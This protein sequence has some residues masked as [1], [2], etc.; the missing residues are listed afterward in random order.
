MPEKFR[1]SKVFQPLKDARPSVL[2]FDVFELDLEQ[3]ELRKNGVPVP[4]APQPFKVLVLLVTH[5]GRIVTR[6]EIQEQL[7]SDST[8]VDFEVGLNRCIRQIRTVLGDDADEPRFIETLPRRGY[9]WIV[10]VERPEVA[11]GVSP[12]LFDARHPSPKPERTVD[13]K[14]SGSP[15]ASRPTQVAWGDLSS[16][17]VS[18]YRVLDLVGGGGMGVVYR[19][20]DI[21]LGRGAALKFLPEELAAYPHALQRFEREARAASALNHPHIC[22]I[23]EFGEH[24]G[25][26]FIAMELL[27]G[28]T[29]A[30]LMAGK[31]LALDQ[32]LDISIQTADA[33][34]AAHQKGIIHRDIKPA[35]IFV[36]NRGEAK[37]LDFGLAKLQE[38]DTGDQGPG[39][40]GHGFG[41]ATEQPGVQ[42][43]GPGPQSP[44]ADFSSAP[45]LLLTL[46]KT[47]VAM[48]TAPYMSP[49]QIRGE[50]LDARTDLFSFGLVLYEMATGQAAFT[51]N[52][53]AEIHEAIV[54]RTP[55]PARELNPNVPPK[56]AEIITRALQ[57][58][59]ELR[60]Q[61]S[62]EL[63][64]DLERVRRDMNLGRGSAVLAALRRWP[65]ATGC[66]S[67]AVLAVSAFLFRPALPP[68]RITRIE[69]VTLGA[70]ID[71]PPKIVADGEHIY[72]TVR[73]GG[74][75][76]LM[77]TSLGGGDGQP[78]KVL[79]EGV[80][81]RALDASPR[82]SPLL[83]TGKDNQLWT[84]FPGASPTRLGN[85][86]AG[87][88]AL[89][90]DGRR[91]AY[92][93]EQNSL[94]MTDLNGGNPRKLADLPSPAT[95]LAWSPNREV[96]RFTAG[97]V[98]DHRSTS[99]WEI[100]SDGRNLHQLLAGW[101]Q[102]ATE[103][104]GS[105][106]PDGRYFV[107][108]SSHGGAIN[109]WALR[110]HGSFWRRS[111]R[112]P[113]QLTSG[114][115]YPFGGTPSRDGLHLFFY[116]GVRQEDLQALDIK[117][118]QFSSFR[119]GGRS[120]DAAFSR[121]GRWIAFVDHALFRSRPDT[122]TDRVQLAPQTLSPG[123][124]RWSPDASWVAFQSVVPGRPVRIYIVSA[125]GGQPQELLTSP[126]DVRDADWSNDGTRLVVARAVGP[127]DSDPN[128]L[129]I[130][131]FAT[132]RTQK[133]PRSDNLVETRWSPDGRYISASDGSQLKL[134][135]FAARRWS[136]IAL[137]RAF[138]FG[139]WSYDSRYLYFQD[140]QG[141]GQP[142]F[143]YD[144]E[145]KRVETIE[146]FSEFLKSGVGR[147]QLAVDLAPDGSPVFFFIRSFYDLFAAEV[148][149]P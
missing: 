136:V 21:K 123:F 50:K 107:F 69:Q 106:T 26:P 126:T 71:P 35:N 85:I 132:R 51:G 5:P 134:W 22:T 118:R 140:L 148:E 27:E 17:R 99:I 33:L 128:E 20:E 76:E 49:E 59:R 117:T 95:W 9:R 12:P 30:R 86:S 7:W 14:G 80:G 56:L 103:C 70:R 53:V 63:R 87:D 72:Y 124:P 79:G 31:P 113:F 98:L 57:K 55:V 138:G 3:Q 81:I 10:P 127:K 141:T 149:F 52:T 101:S 18:H 83:L 89:S 4:L 78:M 114:P 146:N 54:N 137:G 91:I 97:Y 34:D 48:G 130:V 115:D 100:N 145:R 133:I 40:D 92:I 66:M 73:A 13:V 125:Q 1:E 135:S 42:P 74:N 102:P 105:W 11:P 94:W 144:V 29:L 122:V 28:Q 32:L 142:L 39:Q 64:T 19:A 65:R 6:K 58:D 46:S 121:D 109:L 24:E 110:E 120:F 112:G 84:V 147:C 68:P 104:C 37:I 96:L 2:R 131:D 44:A 119:L 111:P 43:R 116:N 88:A 60:Y 25:Q 129:L 36:T 77:Q 41:G 143:R 45:T 90:S 108:T 75:S 82:G 38:S 61:R 15:D 8:F 23:Y 93:H 47:G 16:K 67:I 62:S 139:V